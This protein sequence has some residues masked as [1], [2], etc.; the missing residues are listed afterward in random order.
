MEEQ[1]K[2]L[3]R[4][5]INAVRTAHYPNHPYFYDLCDRYG[6][7]VM[8]EANLESHKFVKHLPRG[9]PEWRDAVVSRGARMVLRD[10]NHPSIIFWSLG[11]E[12]GQGRISGFCARL[13]WIWTKPGRSITKENTLLQIPM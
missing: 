2:L 8:D 12:A 11:N 13:C 7:Y 3:K 6:L 5:N 10:R 1:V 9:K 4:Y